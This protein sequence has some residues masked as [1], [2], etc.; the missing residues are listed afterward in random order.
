MLRFVIKKIEPWVYIFE[1]YTCCVIPT[2]K[3]ESS[4]INIVLFFVDISGQLSDHETCFLKRF[5]FQ[6]LF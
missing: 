4:F 3:N 5:A 2:P 1:V 6:M